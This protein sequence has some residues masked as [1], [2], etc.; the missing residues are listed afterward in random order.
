MARAQLTVLFFVLEMVATRALDICYKEV[1][2]LS[3]VL[4][5]SKLELP[6][7]AVCGRVIGDDLASPVQKGIEKCGNSIWSL[8]ECDEPSVD[9]VISRHEEERIVLHFAEIADWH[10]STLVQCTPRCTHTHRLAP[11]SSSNRTAASMGAEQKVRCSIGTCDGSLPG[12]RTVFPL[13]SYA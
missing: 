11:V 12:H 8:Y 5:V 1:P 13:P 3:R 6:A 4:P 9:L 7:K 2:Q 10:S